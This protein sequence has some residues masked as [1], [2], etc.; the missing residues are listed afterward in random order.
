MKD[1]A[2]VGTV[3]NVCELIEGWDSPPQRQ[4]KYPTE[5]DQGIGETIE[6][7]LKWDVIIPM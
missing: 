6:G 1:K 3:K 4:Y 7:V 5:E 2:E